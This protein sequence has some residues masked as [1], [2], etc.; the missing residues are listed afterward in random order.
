VVADRLAGG[1][2]VLGQQ[3]PQ[4]AGMGF[5][6]R[7]GRAE[8]A[9]DDEDMGA[10]L[11]RRARRWVRLWRGRAHGGLWRGGARGGRLRGRARGGRLRGRARGGRLRG[12]ARGGLWR[13]RARGG[14]LRGRARGGRLR[15]GACGRRWCGARRWHDPAASLWRAMRAGARRASA[16]VGGRM[17][18]SLRACRAGFNSRVAGGRRGARLPPCPAARSGASTSGVSL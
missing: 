3:A 2:A 5:A 13:G 12:R 8:G 15:G 9:V 14:R 4:R 1:G 17:A 10:R 11:G 18:R 6:P 16:G 7:R